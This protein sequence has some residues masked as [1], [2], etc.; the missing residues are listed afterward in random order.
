VSLCSTL[1]LAVADPPLVPQDLDKDDY[2]PEPFRKATPKEV[3]SLSKQQAQE[4]KI[5]EKVRIKKLGELGF[6][7][8]HSGEVLL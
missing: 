6:E 7:V 5:K 1:S 8:E 3:H 4:R 2:V